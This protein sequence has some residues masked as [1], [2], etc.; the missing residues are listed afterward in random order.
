MVEMIVEVD[1]HELIH[2]SS[3][4]ILDEMTICLPLPGPPRQW[5]MA[6]AGHTHL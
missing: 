4:S 2:I 1:S 6:C 5:G 3:V